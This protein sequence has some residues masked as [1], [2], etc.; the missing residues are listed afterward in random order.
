LDQDVKLKAKI[1]LRKL[2]LQ[3]NRLER[4]YRQH[5]PLQYRNMPPLDP[6]V[7]RPLIDKTK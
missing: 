6:G 4:T 7:V 5:R 3:I 1:A 2:Q